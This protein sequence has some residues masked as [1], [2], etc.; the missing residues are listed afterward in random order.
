M[1]CWS[2]ATTNH[3]SRCTTMGAT[4]TKTAPVMRATLNPRLRSCGRGSRCAGPT[5]TNRCDQ[6]KTKLRKSRGIEELRDSQEGTRL[7]TQKTMNL[8]QVGELL[9][10]KPVLTQGASTLILKTKHP[11]VGAVVADLQTLNES[12]CVP[13]QSV[14]DKTSRTVV[15]QH[16]D[17]SFT[18]RLLHRM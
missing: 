12:V 5:F 2:T 1:S 14:E 16:G 13:K 15:F 11:L 3:H 8:F 9:H 10:V 6:T 17:G 7:V 18:M 4:L